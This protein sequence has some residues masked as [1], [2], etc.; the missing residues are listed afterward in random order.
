VTG[1]T[2]ATGPTGP[3]GVTGP[4]GPNGQT[5]PQGATGPVGPQGFSGWPYL[6]GGD[7]FSD[8]S[9]EPQNP[10]VQSINTLAG[11]VTLTAGNSV[12]FET[13]GTDIKINVFA[14]AV[15]RADVTNTLTLT[16]TSAKY[17]FLNP[18][19]GTKTIFLPATPPATGLVFIFKNT[20]PNPYTY[21]FLNI[22]NP[23]TNADVRNL[24]GYEAAATIIYDG[25]NWVAL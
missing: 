24:Y 8:F 12:S 5:G 3:T 11:N 14:D 1:A 25:Q 10:G 20:T 18:V 6:D 2:G 21:W 4:T 22:K 9:L 16:N 19:S 13:T 17:Q 15:T 23:N 7:P